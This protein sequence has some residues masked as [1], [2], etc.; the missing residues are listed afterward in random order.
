MPEESGVA[1]LREKPREVDGV[2][3]SLSVVRT[4]SLKIRTLHPLILAPDSPQPRASIPGSERVL[5]TENMHTRG[6]HRPNSSVHHSHRQGSIPNPSWISQPAEAV[7]VGGVSS[8]SRGCWGIGLVGIIYQ[9]QGCCNVWP[10]RGAGGHWGSLGVASGCVTPACHCCHLG[11]STVFP[12]SLFKG[13]QQWL[14]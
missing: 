3:F 4:R 10:Q 6:V 1:R 9:T 7:T 8:P 2:I 13:G 11:V 14:E 5:L 12:S